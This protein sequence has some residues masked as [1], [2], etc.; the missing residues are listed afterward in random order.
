MAEYI[1]RGYQNKA[2]DSAIYHLN[3]YN[4]P[5][6]I[7]APTGSG[8]SLIIADICHRSNEPLLILQP[9]KEILEQNY[10]KLISYGIRDIGIFSASFKSKE[11]RKYTYATIGSIYKNP[12]AFKQFRKV[13]VD[14]CHLVNPKA[15]EGGKKK[16]GMYNS[17][18]KAIDVQNIC[19]LTASPY[20]I[21]QKYFSET[22]E[23]GESELFYTAH[24][25]TINR[26]P[27]FFFKKFAYTI[28]IKE[29]YDQGFL[30]PL[31]YKFYND[32][33]ISQIKTNTTGADFDEKELERFWDDKRL[34]KLAKIITEID[35]DCK[36]NLIFCSSILQATR[37]CEMLKGFGLSTGIITSDHT[38]TERADI[39]QAFRQGKIKH[40]C[41][42]GVLTIGFDFP[43]LDCITLARPTISLALYYQMVGR[44]MRPDPMNPEKVCTIVDI[45]ENVKRL[46][47]VETIEMGKESDGFRD[48]VKSEVGVISGKPLF[49]FKVKAE[50]K[51]K[52]I[53]GVA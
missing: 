12:E 46:G 14:E 43:A 26:I 33:D 21:I 2:S 31:R 36:H 9:T 17:F 39:I 23:Q 1:L 25:Q 28:S 3:N 29:L 32:F 45:T 16:A 6:V 38:A 48:L 10:N 47:R 4:N 53:T 20:R 50:D 51:I 18:F 41:N 34:Q 8:K 44:G 15:F 24:L 52:K 35:R 49:K 30:C 42:V 13:I 7:V 27:P 5:F 40:L 19:G 22:N 37:C 11:I